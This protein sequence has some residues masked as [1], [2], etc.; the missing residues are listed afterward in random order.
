M[1]TATFDRSTRLVAMSVE[2]VPTRNSPLVRALGQCY[3]DSV[4]Y[5]ERSTEW[6]PDKCGEDIGPVWQARFYE[7]VI[8]GIPDPDHHLP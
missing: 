8:L 3:I 5:D 7:R 2:G 4:R 1:I 6:R